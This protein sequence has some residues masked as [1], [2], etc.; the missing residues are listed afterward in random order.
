MNIGKLGVWAMP[1][2]TPTQIAAFAQRV[3]AWGYPALWIPDGGGADP[4]VRSS[5]MLANTK[6]LI[7]ATGIVNIYGRDPLAMVGGQYA[8]AEQSGGRFLLGIGVSHRPMVEGMRGHKYDR[9]VATMRAYLQGMAKAPIQG[10]NL[11]EKPR[12]ILAAL[13]PNMLALS[14]SDADGAHP[15]FVPPEHT[16]RARAALPPGKWLCPE[17]KVLLETDPAKA[18]AIARKA[19]SMYLTLDNYCNNLLT[20]GYTKDD[21]ANGGSDRLVDAIVAWGDEAAIRRRIQAHWDAGADHVCIQALSPTGAFGAFDERTLEA[22]AP[23][24]R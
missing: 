12:T 13:R 22:L 11:E 18:R 19:M 21:I 6:T 14:A 16:A 2:G 24:R 4:L 10:F 3:E 20:L 17:Q 9:P 8:L 5:W 1:T 15:Y 7:L 23:N